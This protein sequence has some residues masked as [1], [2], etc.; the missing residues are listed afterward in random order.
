[1]KTKN[2]DDLIDGLTPLPRRR[3]TPLVAGIAGLAVAGLVVGLAACGNTR[4]AQH[5]ASAPVAAE[6]DTVTSAPTT[7][8]SAPAAA[9]H[10]EVPVV[11]PAA[12]QPDG[13]AVPRVHAAEGEHTRAEAATPSTTSTAKP[14]K[15]AKK[16]KKAKAAAT[17]TTSKAV[18]PKPAKKPAPKAK[19]PV[20]ATHAPAAPAEKLG[21][22]VILYATVNANVRSGTGTD[23]A[24]VGGLTAGQQVTGRLVGDTGWY[25]IGDGRYVAGSVVSTHKPAPAPVQQPVAPSPSRPKPAPST[26]GSDAQAIL[27]SYLPGPAT[28]RV[29][30]VDPCGRGAPGAYAAVGCTTGGTSTGYTIT[31]V[32]GSGLSP[33]SE[34]ARSLVLHE[35]G[36]VL[37][38]RWAA[39]STQRRQ[40][41]QEVGWEPLADCIAL[42]LGATGSPGGY[43][44]AAGC[45]GERG[46][47]AAAIVAGRD[48]QTAAQKRAAE[49]AA[50]EAAAKKAAEET[51]EKARAAKLAPLVAAAKKIGVSSS[52]DSDRALT[53]STPVYRTPDVD[54][55]PVGT[56]P[57]GT[58]VDVQQSWL[59]AG[60]SVW[61]QIGT[62]AYVL[63]GSVGA[64]S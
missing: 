4:P 50:A 39:G 31:I 6:A 59:Q 60:G 5:A 30:T 57:A 25:H 34:T 16:A 37:E 51:A 18:T 17:T 63:V 27:A 23:H 47:V 36:H 54:S 10:D 46:Q 32:L 8:P 56:L 19:T 35:Y 20:T 44:T 15:K 53:E 33:R 40:T 41:T 13:S 48:Y 21:T 9:T 43:T 3:R 22:E 49:Q 38:L 2:I 64:A 52:L 29:S 28:L 7:A 45:G 12:H 62:H 1:M 58:P 61:D 24:V 26:G 42:R 55:T 14:T 11:A